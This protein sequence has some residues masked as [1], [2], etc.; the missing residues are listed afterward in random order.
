MRD[1]YP[2]IQRSLIAGKILHC[3]KVK[4]QIGKCAVS[5]GRYQAAVPDTGKAYALIINNEAYFHLSA[6][7]VA[8]AFIDFVGRDI[9]KVAWARSV[10]R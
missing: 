7:S 1:L 2:Q 5:V 4:H 9:A 3:T 10:N 8:R 6:A